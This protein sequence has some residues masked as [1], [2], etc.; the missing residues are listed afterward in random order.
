MQCKLGHLRMRARKGCRSKNEAE[1]LQGRT[2]TS[3]WR[4]QGADSPWRDYERALRPYK[5]LDGCSEFGKSRS[6]EPGVAASLSERQDSP[7]Q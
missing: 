1:G 2:P 6:P 4:L 3:R 5:E 7:G